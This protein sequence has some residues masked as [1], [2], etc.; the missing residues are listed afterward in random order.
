MNILAGARIAVRALRVNKLRSILTMLGIIMGVAAVIAMIS[1]GSGAQA[2]IAEQIQSLGANMLIVLSGSRTTGGLRLGTGSQLSLTEEDAWA[3]KREVPLVEA[4]APSMRGWSQVVWGNLNWSTQVQGITPEFF[5]A[6]DWSVVAGQAFAQDAVDG[7]TKVALL[8]ETVARNLFAD[9][10]PLGQVIRIRKVPFTV[11]GVLGKKGQTTWGQDQDDIILVPL[12]TAKRKLLGVS[13][14]NAR[15]VGAISVKVREGEDMKNAE[16]QTRE[17]L[18]QRHR[19][20]PYQ[21][22]DFDIRNLAEYA[23]AQE[24]SSRVMTILLAAIASVSLLVGGIGIMNIMLVSVT[25]RTREIGLRMAVGAR[26]RDILM[27]FLVEAVTL[28][29][30]GGTIGVV[31]GLVTSY[32]IPYFAGW[33]TLVRPE[34][35]VIAF[36]FAAAIGIF[37]GFYPA[38]KAARLNPIEA[39][40]YE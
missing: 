5:E 30:I 18:R 34:A 3:I 39:L 9:S 31:L 7:A 16:T 8:G 36:G 23:A 6:R 20:Q 24:E 29:L 12:S 13:Q 17:L 37:F 27:Q 4:A 26:G 10:D 22:D 38:R 21:D 25:E 40:R 1:V 14:A 35:I 19:L 11:V 15:S 33:R 2:R 32:T 28:S